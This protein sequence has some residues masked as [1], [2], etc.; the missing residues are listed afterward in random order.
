MIQHILCFFP[1]FNFSDD[2]L[3]SPS[4]CPVPVVSLA[5]PQAGNCLSAD[6]SSGWVACTVQPEGETLHIIAYRVIIHA[7]YL[8]AHPRTQPDKQHV[9]A[10]LL[11]GDSDRNL[12]HGQQRVIKAGLTQQNHSIT[13]NNLVISTC[14]LSW[15]ESKCSLLYPQ[16]DFHCFPPVGTSEVTFRTVHEAVKRS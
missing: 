4:V 8:P 7:V 12:I 2:W 14:C 15:L 16:E 13:I 3:L 1:C 9:F 10:D 11:L 6:S 5:Q